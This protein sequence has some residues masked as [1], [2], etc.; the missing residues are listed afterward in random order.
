MNRLRNSTIAAL[1]LSAA[2]TAAFAQPAPPQAAVQAAPAG[3]PPLLNHTVPRL[4]DEAPQNLCQYAGRVLLIVN[5]AS[6][7]GF[8]PQYEGLEALHAKYAAQ[9]LVVLGFPSNDFSQEPGSAK[10]IADFCSNTFGVKFPM[11]SKTHRGRQA[12]APAVPAARAGHRQGAGLELR[13]IPDRP[14]RQAGGLLR[15]YSDTD[16]RRAAGRP[17][18]GAGGGAENEIARRRQQ[19]SRGAY[20]SDS[21]R[22]M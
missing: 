1:L 21:I 3:C 18:K 4:Q 16:K 12:G 10:D 8:T 20:F 11:F 15:K 22:S 13:Q 17:A 14:Q 9:G 6:F 19:R 2:S 5:T 7:C